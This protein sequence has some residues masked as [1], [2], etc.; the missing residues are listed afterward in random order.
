[1]SESHVCLGIVAIL[2]S[3][4]GLIGERAPAQTAP[5]EDPV[6]AL[7]NGDQIRR[8][9]IDISP[10]RVANRFRSIEGRDPLGSADSLKLEQLREQLERARLES[11]IK[12]AVFR[13]VVARMGIDVN[14]HDIAR[15]ADQLKSSIDETNAAREI[16]ERAR[17]LLAALEE[18]ANDRADPDD[19]Y[20]RH[21]VGIVSPEEWKLR[22]RYDVS[23]DRR[24]ML[25]HVLELSNSEIL[26]LEGAAR[27]ALRLEMAI[28]AVEAE[29]VD[30]DAEFAENMRLLVA[31]PDDRV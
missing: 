27:E 3:L 20:A 31:N 11:A 24:R 1:M 25:Q 28:D 10:D 8:S 19:A 14:E 4:I 9:Q 18:V 12:A 26:D 21:L 13:Q 5:G 30:T 6:V 2:M 16:R 17:S 15:R 7:V 23:P 22:V 29:M